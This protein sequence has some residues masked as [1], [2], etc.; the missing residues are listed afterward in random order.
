MRTRFAPDRQ[1]TARMVLTIFLL[2][3]VYVLFVAA[4]IALLRSWVLVVVIAGGF[5]VAQYWFSDKIALMGMRA[6]VVTPEEEPRLHGI[7]D[8]LCATADMPKP[9]VA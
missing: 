4:L 8:R 2:G 7:I 6:R 3:L 9:R 5:L 1:L